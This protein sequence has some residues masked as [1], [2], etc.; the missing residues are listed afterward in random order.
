MGVPSLGPTQNRVP[1][2]TATP[3]PTPTATPSPAT[4]PTRPAGTDVRDTFETRPTPTPVPTPEAPVDAAVTPEPGDVASDG[5]AQ[6]SDPADTQTRNGIPWISQLKPEGA[7]ES[8]DLGDFNC[9]PASFAMVARKAGYGEGLS[10][11]ELISE[12][13]GIGKTQKGTGTS[14]NGA[15][16]MA[17]KIGMPVDRSEVSFPGFNQAW[18]DEQLA[19]GKAVIANGALETPEGPS[20]HFIVVTGKDAEGNYLINDPLNAENRSVDAAGLGEFLARNPL[21]K[22][23]SIAVG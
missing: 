3:T 22:G 11:A 8:Y 9:A 5:A 20:G 12:L 6:V 14:M 23:A 15:L 1:T 10:D 19:K 16:A 21:H 17:N 7:A 4:T 13:A 2:P 18:M